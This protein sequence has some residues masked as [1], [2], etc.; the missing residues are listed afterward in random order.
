MPMTRAVWASLGRLWVVVGVFVIIGITKSVS[1]DI[2]FRD[3]RGEW[4]ETRLLFTAGLLVGLSLLDAWW[5]N[6]WALRGLPTT[7]RSRWSP[8]RL[9]VVLGAL[10]AYHTTYFVYHNLKSW[11]VFNTSR[12][13]WLAKVD[14]AIFF[15]HSPASLLHD[16]LG[17]HYAT[18]FLTAWYESFGTI[19]VVAF[20]ACVVLCTR[21]RQGLVFLASMVWVWIFGVACY[22]AIPSLG[23]FNESPADFAALPHTVIKVNQVR[24]MAQRADLLADPSAPG[25]AAQVSA[26]ASL[27]IGVS[28]VIWLMLGYYGFRTLF[29]LMGLYVALTVVATI[30][31]GWHFFLDDVAGFLIAVAAVR[32]GRLVIYPRSA[33]EER[34][35]PGR[36]PDWRDAPMLRLL[37]GG[38]VSSRRRPPTRAY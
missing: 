17:T 32:L 29:R 8:G 19:V 22:Y 3:P 30:Y 28:T 23:P 36:D 34:E 35:R 18:Y 38:S 6:G 1:I 33:D 37:L 26:F 9:G 2:P 12:D 24:Y 20:V 14:K 11:D 15:G 31:L 5:R 16:L 25:A 7:L 13:A 21:M 4:L 10:A 27:H